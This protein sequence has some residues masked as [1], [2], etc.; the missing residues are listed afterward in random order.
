MASEFEMSM[1]GE[2]MFFLCLQVVQGPDGIRLHQ[3]K[4]LNEVVKKYGMETSKSYATPLSPNNRID[5]DE[6]GVV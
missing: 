5:I 1:I 2:L 6:K 3:R 4:Y